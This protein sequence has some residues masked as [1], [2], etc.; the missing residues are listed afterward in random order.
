MRIPMFWIPRNRIATATLPRGLA[1]GAIGLL[2]LGGCRA[3]PPQV[4]APPAETTVATPASIPAN[5]WQQVQRVRVIPDAHKVPIRSIAIDPTGKNL[6]TGSARLGKLWQLPEGEELVIIKERNAFDALAFSPDG[7]TIASGNHLGRI[8]LFDMHSG[9]ALADID[10]HKHSVAQVAFSPDNRYLASS[11]LE[12]DIKL[13]DLQT[14]KLVRTF[15]NPAADEVISIAFSPDGRYLAGGNFSGGLWLWD[16]QTGERL[17]GYVGHQ[18]P[19]NVLAIDPQGET[20][21]SGS[22]DAAIKI[23]DL[24]TGLLRAT[25]HDHTEA[26]SDIAIS[27]DGTTLASS[28][29][30]K[31]IRLWDLRTAKAIATLEEEGVTFRRVAFGPDSRLLVGAAEDGALWFWQPASL[32]QATEVEPPAVAAP[33]S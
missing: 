3:V 9:S 32:S 5:P 16:A 19:A 17:R 7:E 8:T 4:I 10:A 28:S 27:A 18:S 29:R 30:D 33:A 13:W 24:Q 1:I 15:S 31:T 25:L 2:A 23:W 14:K 20:L 22:F 11:S 21:I 6:A 12:M 26:I